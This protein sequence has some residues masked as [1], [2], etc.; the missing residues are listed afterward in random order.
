MVAA[1]RQLQLPEVP[2]HLHQPHPLPELP[3]P[4]HPLLAGQQA[5]AVVADELAVVAARPLHQRHPLLSTRNW[6]RFSP[7]AAT[8]CI[9]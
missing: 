4:A 1:V 8:A 3:Q 2:R 6:T 9:R 5:L 7:M